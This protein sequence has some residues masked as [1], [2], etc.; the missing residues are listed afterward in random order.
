MAQKN[1]I[2]IFFAGM[3]MLWG[4]SSWAFAQTRSDRPPFPIL[5]HWSFDAV[6]GDDEAHVRDA[7]PHELHGQICSKGGDKIKRVP[8]VRGQALQF[9]KENRSWVE[10]DD[11]PQ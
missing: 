6:E 1:C 2:W 9:P 4:A 8:G 5:A 7:G 3:T 11:A 10:L